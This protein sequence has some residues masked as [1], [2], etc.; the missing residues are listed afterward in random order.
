MNLVQ[1]MIRAS[2]LDIQLYEEVEKDQEATRQA[3][4]VVL[5]A[6]ICSGVGTLEVGEWT[7][8]IKGLLSEVIGWLLWSGLIFLTAMLLN[9]RLEL[10]ELLRCLGFAYSPH[11][12]NLLG[13]VPILGF[14]IFAV[15]FLW[16]IAAFVVAVRQALDCETGLAILIVILSSIPDVITRLALVI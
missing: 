16:G 12:L 8:L 7:G 14:L 11:A 15:A 9:R 4:L 6:G 5:I 2:M 13:I 3:Y 10:G 1:K